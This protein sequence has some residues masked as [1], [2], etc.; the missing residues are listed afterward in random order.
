[1][2]EDNA[3]KDS[4]LVTEFATYEDYLDSQITPVDLYY[5]ENKELARQL[6]ELGYRGNGEPIKREEFEKRKILETGRTLKRNQQFQNNEIKN[7]VKSES[8]FVVALKKR[9]D[10]NRKGKMMTIIF[11]RDRNRKGQEISG[12]ID[13]CH[14]IKSD[15]NFPYYCMIFINTVQGDK[16]MSPRSG[17]LSFYNWETGVTAVTDSPNFQVISDN[18]KGLMFKN[19]RDRKVL[20]VDPNISVCGDNTSR[21]VLETSEYSQVVFYDHIL[22]RKS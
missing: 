1:M 4:T 10:A 16:R 11:L 3:Q 20:N 9:D 8:E 5:L 19:K 7:A 22:L 17:D 12:Y 13:L 15:F 2:I 21:E 6:V 18:P 14:R